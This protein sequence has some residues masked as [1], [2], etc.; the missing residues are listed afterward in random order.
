MKRS[1]SLLAIAAVFALAAAPLR[2]T[3]RWT[4]LGPV[5]GSAFTFTPDPA[6]PGVV[7]AT[8]GEHGTFKTVDGGA[9]WTG[10]QRSN[11]YANL[12]VDPVRPSILYLPAWPGT[13][14]KSGDGGAHWA[15]INNGLPVGGPGFIR[16][17]RV[18][19]ALRTRVY[20]ATASGVW[21]SLDGGASWQRA[22]AG[23][24]EGASVPPAVSALAAVRPA[25]TVFAG[26][27]SG[28][29]RSTN[30]ARSWQRI[31]QVL[32]A[33]IV[34]AIVPAPSDP[35][36]LY[37]LFG[38]RGLYRTTN[39]G[40]SWR[41]VVGPPARSTEIF[42]LVVD[43]RS[44]TT[45]YTS[46]RGGAVLRSTDGALHWSEIGRLP[47]DFP[48]AVTPD[49]FTPGRLY[50]SLLESSVMTGGVYRSDDGGA[51]WQRRST[52]YAALTAASLA[53]SP[54]DPERLWTLASTALFR[55]DGPG[56]PWTR[57]GL[58][59]GLAFQGPRALAAA[60]SSTLFLEAL[61]PPGPPS[62]LWRTDD[63]GASWTPLHASRGLSL[64]G[65]RLAPSDPSTLYALED[66]A[67]PM[68]GVDLR[69]TADG[70]ATWQTRANLPL[71]CHTGDLAVAP[72]S[73]QVLYVTGGAF[74]AS[75][76]CARPVAKVYRSRDG[77]AT[78]T[79]TSA[80]LPTGPV[81]Q[82][83]VDPGD[84]DTV[85]VAMGGFIRTPGDGVWKTVDGGATWTRAGTELAGKTVVAL[86][87]T[88][89]PGH[90]YA[91][92]DDDRVFR[93]EDGG[94]SWEDVTD[95]LFATVIYQLVADPADPGRVYAATANGNWVLEED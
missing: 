89:L 20:L 92:L 36:T 21:G 8:A 62:D 50:A 84:P 59:P 45:L 9:T 54:D 73:A 87:A 24:L 52:G 37:V 95:G 43:P 58:P 42:S 64:R 76:S 16:A 82:A 79:D 67:Y 31:T 38:S 28:L 77:G 68:P 2:A 57:V 46:L 34:T 86:L 40:N 48:A 56:L 19:P 29:Y 26:T 22:N 71:T 35:Q 27:A 65:F 70:G 49:P 66:A 61:R 55:S 83:T 10:I 33:A 1:I 53:V 25:G 74:G 23:L 32:P 14:L 78:F 85:Y 5:G 11:A 94:G 90:V 47:G 4:L 63:A 7:Y 51:T 6:H 17:V 72:S 88:D 12:A 93:T 60:S 15:A 44:P 75:T 13:L 81:T 41:P 80:G 3:P 91:A 18:D 30:G 39:G 69:A